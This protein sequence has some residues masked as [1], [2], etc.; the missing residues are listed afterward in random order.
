MED[1]KGCLS[2]DK[3]EPQ[4]QQHQ[5]QAAQQAENDPDWNQLARDVVMF[6]EGESQQNQLAFPFDHS[7]LTHEEMSTLRQLVDEAVPNQEE[8]KGEGKRKKGCMSPP[9]WEASPFY[10]TSPTQPEQ[11]EHRGAPA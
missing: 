10:T 9:D 3:D 2:L 6:P 7:V 8:A 1:I 11:C 5:Q 4:E